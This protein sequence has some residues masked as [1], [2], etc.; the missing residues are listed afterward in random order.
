M[1][2]TLPVNFTLLLHSCHTG[3]LKMMTDDG[4]GQGDCNQYSPNR[5]KSA[6]HSSMENTVTKSLPVFSLCMCNDLLLRSF[7]ACQMHGVVRRNF[8]SC[9]YTS[10]HKNKLAHRA[11]PNKCW[12]SA[13][14]WRAEMESVWAHS[15][16]SETLQGEARQAQGVA[17]LGRAQGAQKRRCLRP[18]MGKPMELA[19]TSRREGCAGRSSSSSPLQIGRQAET[20]SDVCQ[21]DHFSPVA[22]FCY[23]FLHQRLR[24]FQFAGA[25]L[26]QQ[27]PSCWAA[28]ALPTL[29]LKGS[30]FIWQVPAALLHWGCQVI[31]SCTWV[32][33]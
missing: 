8:S 23:C 32:L 17:V 6:C 15:P 18:L 31:S 9:P 27:Q 7:F 19:V 30:A 24:I 12:V 2:N 20:V 11:W 29:F 5:F 1:Q 16:D 26:A 14:I 28:S 21:R 3:S 10:A 25:H 33:L 4:D 13:V 22:D